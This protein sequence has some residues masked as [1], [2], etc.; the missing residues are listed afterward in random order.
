MPFS[1]ERHL[2][3]LSRLLNSINNF[4]PIHH[5]PAMQVH[6]RGNV[7]TAGKHS[8]ETTAGNE[9]ET[10]RTK[11]PRLS[12]S[13]NKGVTREDECN[14]G[15]DQ[16]EDDANDSDDGDYGDLTGDP[17]SLGQGMKC[18]LCQANYPDS[19]SLLYVASLHPSI[20]THSTN[21]C[22]LQTASCGCT[23]GQ[24][25][26]Y[27]RREDSCLGRRAIRDQGRHDREYLLQG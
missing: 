7:C 3:D 26:S 8:A 19:D 27:L 25:L 1:M 22:R 21:G 5:S 24:L 9:G 15:E 14:E 12:T 10:R 6:D 16:G 13:N 23:P 18:P 4:L 17:K 2:E 11:R 20:G